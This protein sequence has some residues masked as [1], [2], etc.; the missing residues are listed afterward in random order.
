MA[1]TY[2]ARFTAA[3]AAV[4]LMAA[5]LAAHA[6]DS[7]ATR[8]AQSRKSERYNIASAGSS[9]RT[10]GARIY[11]QAPLATARS[12]ATDYGHYSQFP[13]FQKSRV[14][15]K[16]DGKTDV[17]LQLGILHGA[18]TVWALVRFDPPVKEGTGERIEGHM[19]EGN[20]DDMRATWH[21]IPT[22]DGGTI[23]KCELLVEPKLHLPGSVVTPELEYAADQAATSVR[24]R[25]EAKAKRQAPSAS[26]RGE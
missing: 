14:V 4:S 9:I 2:F 18:A 10:G 7:E 12:V 13:R 8:L 1:S 19:V 24:D 6:E 23:V 22:D 21:L 17:Y 16:K 11:V 20:V 26:A 3:L 25:S 15:A 5:P